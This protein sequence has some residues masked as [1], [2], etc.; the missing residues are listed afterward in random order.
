MRS[1]AFLC[2]C[3]LLAGLSGCKVSRELTAPGERFHCETQDD[4]LAGFVCDANFCIPE[5]TAGPADASGGGVDAG[6]DTVSP[7]D[8]GSGISGP[9]NLLT[10]E[11]CI[12][13]KGCFFD[14][15]DKKT[16]TG[17]G[18]KGAGQVCASLND[19][20][21]GL[22]CSQHAGGFKCLPTCDTKKPDC[23][24]GSTCSAVLMSN[25]EP[26]PDRLG[27]CK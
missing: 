15:Y 4:C 20:K 18:L 10:W 14:A 7:A 21:M 5:G 16:C 23:P 9:C 2:A 13:G 24:T 19:C 8:T 22:L 26:W 6:H 11:G 17:H 12:T 27:V 1:L 3:A 25:D